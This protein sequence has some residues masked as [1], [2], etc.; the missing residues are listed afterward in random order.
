MIALITRGRL[1]SLATLF[2]Q[3]IPLS[4]S[5]T[6]ETILTEIMLQIMLMGESN[7]VVS[8]YTLYRHLKQYCSHPLMNS[9][10]RALFNAQFL[11][12]TT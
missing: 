10:I 6:L 1:K 11:P 8:A 4:L 3:Y 7:N 12:H 9:C 2:N 5:S